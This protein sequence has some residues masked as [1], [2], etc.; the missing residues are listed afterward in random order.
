[1]KHLMVSTVQITSHNNVKH[2]MVSTVQIT[3]LNNVKHLMVSTV[4]ITSHNNVKHLMVSTVQITSLNNVQAS[5]PTRITMVSKTTSLNTLKI[6][7]MNNAKHYLR[8]THIWLSTVITNNTLYKS[9]YFTFM[10]VSG[11]LTTK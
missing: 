8:I 1:V 5:H 3:S 6:N 7:V 10:V 2:L 9:V 11:D 4:Q